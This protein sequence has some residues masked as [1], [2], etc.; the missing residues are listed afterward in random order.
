MLIDPARKYTDAELAKIEHNLQ[1]MYSEAQSD[2][3]RRWNKALAAAKKAE[4]A[5]QKKL[6]AAVAKGD[7]KLIAKLKLERA[8]L[9]RKHTIQSKRFQRDADAIAGILSD[10]NASAVQLINGHLKTVYSANYNALNTQLPTAYQYGLVTPETVKNLALGK[11]DYPRD[12]AFNRRYINNQILQGII[13]GESIPK[14]AKR[15][16][17]VV[18]MDKAAAV[19]TART[20][21]TY[22][23]NKGRFDSYEAAEEN[24]TVLRK[25]WAATHDSRVRHSHLMCE[26]ESDRSHG[27][28]LD[29][30]FANGLLYPGDPDGEDADVYNCRCALGVEIVGFKDRFGRIH[31]V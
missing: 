18:G 26:A 30:R 10:V 2:L 24:G 11:L 1:Q 13:H 31:Y 29:K 28:E 21:V 16:Q 23:E 19:R 4:D 9:L 12:L 20:N 3:Y 25:M 7:Q 5:L 14:I 22:A 8:R 6:D 17:N 27:L 15:I